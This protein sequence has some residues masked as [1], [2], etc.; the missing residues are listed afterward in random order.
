MPRIVWSAATTEARGQ[1][2]K[3]RLD[4]GGQTVAPLFG[5]SVNQKLKQSSTNDGFTILLIASRNFPRSVPQLEVPTRPF[6]AP[7]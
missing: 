7:H 6:T 2:A 1:S 5:V 3:H 4:L